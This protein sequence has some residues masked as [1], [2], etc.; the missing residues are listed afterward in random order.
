ML[1]TFY[2]LSLSNL[3]VRMIMLYIM[4]F[5]TLKFGKWARF[6]ILLRDPEM[7]SG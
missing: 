1:V 4:S 6:G 7:N 3:E 5:Q 2:Y